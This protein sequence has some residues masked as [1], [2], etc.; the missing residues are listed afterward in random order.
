MPVTA[1]EIRLYEEEVQKRCAVLEMDWQPAMYDEGT[2][3]LRYL[4]ILACT[5]IDP[6]EGMVHDNT[7]ASWLREV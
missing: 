2:T 4:D 7:L 6:K 3:H 5:H 1:E